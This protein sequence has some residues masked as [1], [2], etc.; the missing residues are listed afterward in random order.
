MTRR[1]LFYIVI[2][3][4]V[5]VTVWIFFVDRSLKQTQYELVNEIYVQKK[6]AQKT[7]TRQPAAV[8]T[9]VPLTPRQMAL[10]QDLENLNRQIEEGEAQRQRQQQSLETLQAQIAEQNEAPTRNTTQI[11]DYQAEILRFLEDIQRTEYAKGEVDRR[12][13]FL[14][15]DQGN[16][17][18]IAR[19]QLDVTIQNQESYMREIQGQIS[20][21]Q[22][23]ASYF[24]E[25]QQKL[26]ELQEQ[27]RE[28]NLLLQDLKNQRASIGLQTQAAARALQAEKEQALSDLADESA[29]LLQEVQGLRQEVQRLQTSQYQ[30]QRSQM[31]LRSQIQQLQGSLQRQDTALQGLRSEYVSKQQELESISNID[32]TTGRE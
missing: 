27:W 7:V 14:L 9:S 13:S 8:P 20:Y 6:Q 29:S 5:G 26:Q 10:Q 2:A 23:N 28:Q 11:R 31:S 18:Q 12:S 32:R 25:Q 22:N 1:N 15:S 4:I 30:Q 16:S 24:N 21:W 19:E 3:F 17:A